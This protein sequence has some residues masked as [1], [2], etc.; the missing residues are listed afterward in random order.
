MTSN[1]NMNNNERQYPML[2][3]CRVTIRNEHY[4][5]D[6]PP[7]RLPDDII[8]TYT[9]ISNGRFVLPKPYDFAL[10]KI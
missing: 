8:N 9:N 4:N 7:V 5:K 3:S 1:N 10:G 2:V 6:R